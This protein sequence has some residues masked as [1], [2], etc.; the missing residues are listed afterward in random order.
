MQ[1][2]PEYRHECLV[3]NQVIH[4][5]HQIQESFN[6]A[7]AQCHFLKTRKEKYWKNFGYMK[8]THELINNRITNNRVMGFRLVGAF[9]ATFNYLK[10]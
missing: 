9:Q 3:N 10:H 7:L 2:Q 8:W 5:V 1:E 6:G 4:L